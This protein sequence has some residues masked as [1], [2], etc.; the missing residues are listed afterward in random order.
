MR[1]IIA[2][3][4]F[5]GI[6]GTPLI[7]QNRQY[8]VFSEKTVIY[9]VVPASAATLLKQSGYEVIWLDCIAEEIS[10]SRFMEII[11]QEKP[12]L[13]AFETKTPVVKQHWQIINSLKSQAPGLECVLFGDHVT[14]L[15][16]ESL[17]NSKVDFVLTGG[18]YDFLLLSLCNSLASNIGNLKTENRKP[19]TDLEPGIYY[20]DN[21]QIK[22]TGPFKLNHDLNALPFIDRELTRWQLYAFKNGN[23]KRTPGTYMM[24]ARDCWY[25]KCTFCSWPTLYPEFRARRPENALDEIGTLIERYAIREIMDDSGSFPVGE[26]LKSFCQIEKI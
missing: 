1:V 10:Y 3:P 9:P 14:A 16:E 15:P 18:D 26:W 25:H 7:S 5:P 23:Y 11:Q 8:Q 2:Y 24:S 13:I 21:G 22:N 17:E 19:K 6:K 12:D 4:P 20:R